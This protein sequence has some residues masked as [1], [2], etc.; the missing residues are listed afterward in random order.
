[1]KDEPALLVRLA[2]RSYPIHLGEGLL[3]RAGQLIAP[4]LREP[5]VFL[6]V[7]ANLLDTPHPERLA[8]SLA[9]ADIAVETLAVPPGEGSKSFAGLERLI[10]GLLERGIERRSTILALGGGVVGDLAGFAAAI[11]LRGVD[12]VQLPTTLLAQVDSAVGGK[13]GID[14][15]RGKNLVGAFKQPRAVVADTSALDSLPLRELRAGYAEIVKYGCI[16]DAA[17]FAWLEE[18]GGKLLAGDPEARATA[19]RR[20]LEIK[21]A[22]VAR[23]EREESGERAL[24]NFGHTFAHAYEALAGYGSRLLHGEAVAIGMV[25]AA[26]LSARLGLAPETD[27]R[28]LE[29]HLEASGLPIS[30][31]ALGLSFAPEAL[32]AR[33]RHDKKVAAG[34]PRFVLWRGIGDAVLTEA[35]PRDMLYELLAA[36]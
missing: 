16:R 36:G 1:M 32:L 20:S 12:Y 9:T 33:M 14:T 18:H 29:R 10:D 4:V 15:A 31:R 7:D 30:P 23:D 25:A 27:A 3:D 17:F 8:A 35:V 34:R 2:D 21:A 24:L 22:I 6:V 13:T 28:R 11:V 19:V 5:R 26:R